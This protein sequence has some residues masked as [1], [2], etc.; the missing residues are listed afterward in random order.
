M[1]YIV[2]TADVSSVV[3]VRL[4]PTNAF[5]ESARRV[6]DSGRRVQETGD[7]SGGFG[8]YS[9][10]YLRTVRLIVSIWFRFYAR[11]SYWIFRRLESKTIFKCFE[12]ASGTRARIHKPRVIECE[13]I[14]P[15]NDL[16][17]YAQLLWY[18]VVHTLPYQ[19]HCFCPRLRVQYFGKHCL[20][21]NS[22]KPFVVA[23]RAP[24][25][26]REIISRA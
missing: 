5:V 17:L 9:N 24:R 6:N 26:F 14:P 2:W 8:T 18:T 15:E 21:I 19:M 11:T 1:A 23:Q 10:Q 16:T 25:V 12:N 7:G 4:L 20:E 13:L 22:I 3:I